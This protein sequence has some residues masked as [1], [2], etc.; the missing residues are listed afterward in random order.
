[1]GSIN[2]GAYTW[3]AANND[4]TGGE[5]PGGFE[6]W[7]RAY[8]RR[9]LSYGKSMSNLLTSST[10]QPPTAAQVLAYMRQGLFLGFFPGFA[11]EYWNSPASYERD[12]SIVKQYMG[13]IKKVYLAGWRPVPYA[14][15]PDSSIYVERFDD[16]SGNTFYLT[17]FNNSSS[18]KTFQVTVDGASLGIGSG[19][20][21]LKELVGNTSISASRS[22]SNIFFSDTLATGETALYEMTVGTG[23]DPTYGDLNLDGRVDSIDLVILSN[24]LV[25]NMT[26][27]SAPFTATLAKADLDRSGAVDAVDLVVLQNFLVGNVTCLPR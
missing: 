15:T 26:Y 14:S 5:C 20:I 4:I 7:E 6:A 1:M 23:C 12:R 10:N 21:T 16:Q 24:Y 11:P 27:E 19:A 22:G 13:L 8:T 25:G 2:P 3:F 17:A 9:T 18:T